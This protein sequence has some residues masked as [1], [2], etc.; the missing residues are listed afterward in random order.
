MTSSQGPTPTQQHLKLQAISVG[1]SAPTKAALWQQG[2]APAAQPPPACAA[3][4]LG[5]EELQLPSQ[6]QLQ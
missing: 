6:L 2:A 5:A 3:G 4:R 1:I